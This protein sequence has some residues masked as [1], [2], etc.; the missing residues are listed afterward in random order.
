MIS[1]G[2]YLVNYEVGRKLSACIGFFSI[3]LKELS[4]EAGIYLPAKSI[5]APTPHSQQG[6][7]HE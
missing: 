4:I 1:L 2:K 7:R 6:R 3:L 5:R